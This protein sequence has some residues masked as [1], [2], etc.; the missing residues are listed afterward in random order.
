MTLLK[1][2]L[3]GQAPSSLGGVSGALALNHDHHDLT[4]TITITERSTE[5][6][7]RSTDHD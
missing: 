6:G 7:A 2:A 5:H 3:S 1:P 4:I